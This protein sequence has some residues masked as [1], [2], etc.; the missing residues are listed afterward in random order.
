MKGM[1]LT[2]VL[3]FLFFAPPRGQAQLPERSEQLVVSVLAW[4]GRDYSPTFAPEP[5]GAIYL[6]A[7]RDNFL[8]VRKTLMYWWP[9]T[10]EWKTDTKALNVQLSGALELRDARGGRELLSIQEYTFFNVKSEY[11][12]NWKVAKDEAAR[13]E[14]SKYM[15]LYDSYFKAEQEYQEKVGAYEAEMQALVARIQG[16]QDRGMDAATLIERLQNLEKP[17]APVEPGYYVVPPAGLQEAFILNLPQGR[18]AIRLMNP[19]GSVMEGSEKT[20]FVHDKL[21]SGGV[22]F[23]VIPGDKWT[24]SV[25]SVTPS[26]VLYVSGGADLYLRPFFEDEFNDLAYEKT[27]NNAARANPN[28]ATW[29]RIQQVPRAGIA[30]RGPDGKES[31]L[32]ERPFYV[33]QAPGTNLGYTILPFDPAGAH[34]DMEPSLIAFRVPL[35]KGERAFGIRVLDSAGASLSGSERQ[36][37]IV[38]KMPFPALLMALA[39]T[40]L[41][42]MGAV[43]LL[44][45][46]AYATTTSEES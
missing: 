17:E 21:R 6:M 34:K 32:A 2:L 24:R 5:S 18:Y 16:L 13:A 40:P 10:A 28:I 14:L 29:V 35:G 1:A 33:E 43:L 20:V 41:L 25:T 26:S 45:R 27:V 42:L 7:G 38:G 4:N 37:R 19:D 11:E 46:R 12:Q 23:E 39:L 22:G 15:K 8:T 44:R 30:L 36:I 3:L 9:L 31:V